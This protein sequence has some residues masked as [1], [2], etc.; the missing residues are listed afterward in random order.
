VVYVEE[1][2]RP[3]KAAMVSRTVEK[4]RTSAEDAVVMAI[5]AKNR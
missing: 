3:V 5:V 1:M 2:T 4:C